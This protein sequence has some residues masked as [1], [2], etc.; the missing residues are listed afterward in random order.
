VNQKVL[1]Y[2]ITVTDEELLIEELAKQT[3]M[4]RFEDPALQHATRSLKRKELEG[5][6]VLQEKTKIV[7]M[8]MEKVGDCPKSSTVKQYNFRVGKFCDMISSLSIY[9]PTI[10]SDVSAKSDT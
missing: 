6:L 10:E 3:E 1:V 8:V 9:P 2:L 4:G 5:S 7:K